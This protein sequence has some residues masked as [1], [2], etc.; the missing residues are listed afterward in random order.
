MERATFDAL[1]S[2]EGAGLLAEASAA[3]GREDEFALGTRLRRAHAPDLV[4]AAL[5]Q[6]RLR[7]RAVDKFAPADA[8]RMFFTV[9]GYEQ[10]TRVRVARHRAERLAAALGR[11]AT[12]ADLC[13]GI[14]G[15][16]VELARAGLTVTGVEADELTAAV[17][18]ANAAALGVPAQVR[19]ADAT[20]TDRT[21]YA[22]VV[23]DPARRGGRGRVF[24]PDAY[25][26]PWSFVLELLAATACVKVAPGLPHERIPGGVEA[27]WVSER[28]EVKE[29]AL[30]SGDLACDGVR[31]R[32]TLLPSGATLTDR[33]DPGPVVRPLGAYLYE[34][35]GAVIRAGLVTAA[36]ARVGGGL[37]DPSIAYVTADAAVGTPFARGYRVLDTLPY[38]VKAL[39]RY[40]RDHGIGV[41][42]VK[43]RGVGVEP[44]KLRA[45]V[46]PR[47]ERT[48]TF[49]VTRV[50][51]AA[52]VLVADP[53]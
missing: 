33:D 26:P 48:A 2:V 12:V 30:W 16:L 17:A 47:G 35:D 8:A 43:K 42:T 5:T 38:D 7:A 40:V 9:D 15:D 22:A 24:D 32:A 11:G 25:R 45:A 20:T 53:L 36:A 44:E 50:A 21:G 4:A 18:A 27:E 37:L 14:G 41:L 52:T 1:R 49:V 29:A 46:R 3:Y 39:R 34:P 6:A 13:C 23:C 51:G 31:R 10:A 19:H 28:G